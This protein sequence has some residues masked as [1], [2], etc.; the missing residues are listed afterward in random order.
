M[1]YGSVIMRHSLLV[2]DYSSVHN[3]TS[4]KDINFQEIYRETKITFN[5]KCI[6]NNRMELS[7]PF[8]IKVCPYKAQ[9]TSAFSTH[10]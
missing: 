2:L 9:Q 5:I 6:P 4:F 7:V 1:I 8:T 10:L 3:L